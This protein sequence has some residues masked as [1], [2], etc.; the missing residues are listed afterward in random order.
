METEIP[1]LTLEEALAVPQKS[2]PVRNGE[3]WLVRHHL[4]NISSVAVASQQPFGKS[5]L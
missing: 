2:V 3:E 5:Y 1:L 4:K